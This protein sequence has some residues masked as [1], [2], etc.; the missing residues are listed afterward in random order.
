MS[1]ARRTVSL[2]AL[3]PAL[4]CASP[5]PTVFSELDAESAAA[6]ARYIRPTADEARWR[7]VEW[8]PNFAEGMRAAGR[9]GRPLLF[10]AMNGHPLGCT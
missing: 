1:L 6:Y 8:L 4:A 3:L 10:W 5:A 7:D 2:V 9:Q